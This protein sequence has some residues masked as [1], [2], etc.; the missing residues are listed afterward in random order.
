MSEKI[1]NKL[2]TIERKIIEIVYDHSTKGG[3]DNAINT[4]I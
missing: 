4:L 1:N 2:A 3:T